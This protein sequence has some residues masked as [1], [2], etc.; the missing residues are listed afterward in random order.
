LKIREHAR[1]Y[2]CERLDGGR[3]RVL[4]TDGDGQLLSFETARVLLAFGRRG[5]PRTLDAPIADAMLD[6]VHYSLADARSFAGRSICVVGLGDVAMEAAI[7]LANQADTRVMITY[8]GTEFTRGKRRN[9][10][11]L[12]RLIQAGRVEMLWGTGVVRIEPGRVQLQTLGATRAQA[13]FVVRDVDSVFV[14]IGNIAPT[15]LLDA[16]GVRTVGSE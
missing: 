1:V 16:F 10:D 7:G 8:R 12:R 11:E 9:V 13:P 14:L 3:L 5:S 4:A 15:K 6:H 2:G